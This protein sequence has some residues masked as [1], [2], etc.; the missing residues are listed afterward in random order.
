MGFGII[1]FVF[2]ALQRQYTTLVDF[3]VLFHSTLAHICL[4]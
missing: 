1:I 2:D 4:Y 3:T